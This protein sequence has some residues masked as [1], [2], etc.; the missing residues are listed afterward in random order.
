[1]S[2]MGEDKTT[3]ATF[4][5]SQRYLKLNLFTAEIKN[6]KLERQYRLSNLHNQRMQI[7]ILSGVAIMAAIVMNIVLQMN[8]VNPSAGYNLQRFGSLTVVLSGFC[9][10]VWRPRSNILDAIVFIFFMMALLQVFQLKAFSDPNQLSLL[11]RII[12]MIAIGQMLMP[13]R[14][15]LGTVC[16]LVMMLV[17]LDLVLNFLILSSADKITLSIII[18]FMTI[19]GTVT[20]WR[21]EINKRLRF[22][23]HS[24]LSDLTNKLQDSESKLR[25]IVDNLP[26]FIAY[27]DLEEQLQFINQ[28][29]RDWFAIKHRHRVK[30]SLKTLL[31]ANYAL[32]K[33]QVRA[34]LAGESL[35]FERCFTYPDGQIRTVEISHLP[36][37]DQD[38]NII[39]Y[40]S[41]TIDI[42]AVK[43]AEDELIREKQSAEQLART[44]E[45]TGIY[46]RRAFLELGSFLVGQSHRQQRSYAVIMV[47]IDHFKTVN[48]VHGHG[49]GDLAIQAVATVLAT[50]LR[51]ADVL[52]RIGGE[53][54]AIVMGPANLEEA[55]QLAERLRLKIAAINIPVNA[56]LLSFTASFGVAISQSNKQ[57]LEEMLSQADSALYQAKN[58]G[59]DRVESY[60]DSELSDQSV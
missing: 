45:L 46:N 41:Q 24:Q 51:A 27:I 44:D 42:S 55:M 12:A 3:Q 25:L 50:T 34:T 21:H 14:Y 39:G 56:G 47:D 37:R 8:E 4:L 7:I 17:G 59:R 38:Q 60:S 9:V 18:L 28:T 5:K 11:G 6:R 57:Y 23:D 52:A 29:G 31:G 33:D 36:H 58:A 32:I 26:V 19:V 48:D 20:R 16:L 35:R 10:A 30:A 53:E 49:V 40:I 22:L 2:P 54:F 43:E 1:M 15:F 13:T